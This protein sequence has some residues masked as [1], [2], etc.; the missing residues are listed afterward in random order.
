MSTSVSSSDA[1]ALTSG[2]FTGTGG[3]DSAVNPSG[4]A[5]PD[6]DEALPEADAGAHGAVGPVTG[7][8]HMPNAAQPGA[9]TMP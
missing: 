8:Q 9:M 3:H 4:F 1:G 6:T 7:A 5:S 2:A